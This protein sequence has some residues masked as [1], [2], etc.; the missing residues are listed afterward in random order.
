MRLPTLLAD[1]RAALGLTTLVV[2]ALMMVLGLSGKL[3]QLPGSGSDEREVTA[4][5][6]TSQPIRSGTEVRVHG[7][8]VGSVEDVRRDGRTRTAVVTMKV[9]PD[10]PDLYASA[11]ASLRWRTVLGGDFYV[12]V[13]PGEASS[14]P[15]DPSG[16]PA[17][18]TETQVEL[19]DVTSIV[20]GG[21]RSGLQALPGALAEALSDERV[22]QRAFERLADVSPDVAGGLRPLRGTVADQDLRML[23]RESATTMRALDE[24]RD[25]LRRL[26]AGAAA[27]FQTTAGRAAQLRRAIAAGPATL[28]STSRTTSRLNTTLRLVD[29]L[30]TRLRSSAADVGPTL[31]RVRPAVVQADRLLD[32]AEPLVAS[33]RPAARG[34][35]G[36]ATNGLPLL[37]QLQPS[38]D[39]IDEKILPML[40]EKDAGTGKSTAV[41]IGGALAAVGAGTGA[42]V[43]TNGHLFAFPGTSGNSPLYTLPCQ[44]Y[45]SNPDAQ[46]LF[47]CQTLGEAMKTYFSYDLLGP[48]PG[49]DPGGGG[50]RRR[51]P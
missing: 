12:D 29:P 11:S 6:A 18:R 3:S 26:V 1:R 34:L 9:E 16:I 40:S 5:F 17:R 19:D 21:A 4:A 22:P 31:A 42:Q 41:M 37:Q 49:A 13:D 10:T 33:L 48:T 20:Q 27:T 45:F 7:V 44:T 15:L 32:R 47:A 23:I 51:S 36:A 46:E 24:P 2:G 38:L 8:T 30:L 50:A 35:R 28:E 43:D 14:G 25:D 39:R